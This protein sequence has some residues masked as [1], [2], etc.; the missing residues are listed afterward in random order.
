MK[1]LTPLLACAAL[2]ALGAGPPS[3]DDEV[4]VT[5]DAGRAPDS[6]PSSEAGG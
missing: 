6:G 3:A 2:R 5:P 1:T 4:L